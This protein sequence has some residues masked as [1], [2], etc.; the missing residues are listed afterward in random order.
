[1]QR[2]ALIGPYLLGI[3]VGTQAQLAIGGDGFDATSMRV[4]AGSLAADAAQGVAC[5]QLHIALHGHAGVLA[6]KQADGGGR[7]ECRCDRGVKVHQGLGKLFYG[8]G[9]GAALG[10]FSL[11][12]V[13]AAAV[14]A[15]GLRAHGIGMALHRLLRIEAELGA[16]APY[17]GRAEFKS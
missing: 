17:K 10:F 14:F 4:Q 8:V 5:G 6:A 13:D 16:A 11:L 1:M 9:Q 15:L 3:G 7:D 2:D 12:A